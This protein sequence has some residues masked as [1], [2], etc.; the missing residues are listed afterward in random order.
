M[1][2]DRPACAARVIASMTI[3]FV[4][5]FV[6]VIVYCVCSD[7]PAVERSTEFRLF[8]CMNPA[9]DVGKKQLAGSLRSRFTELYVEE[10]QSSA[11]LQLLVRSY[12]TNSQPSNQLVRGIIK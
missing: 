8:C 7:C 5:V 12:L 10:V 2:L 4:F 6:F 11:D 9:T 1:C 3:V